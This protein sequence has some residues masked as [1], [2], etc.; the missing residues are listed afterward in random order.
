MICRV[1]FYRSTELV[2]FS[3]IVKNT[4]GMGHLLSL[5]CN[6]SRSSKVFTLSNADKVES[7]I[8]ESWWR[9]TR[10]H[11]CNVARRKLLSTATQSCFFS[12]GTPPGSKWR[13]FDGSS[14]PSKRSGKS[15]WIR[16]TKKPKNDRH[17]YKERSLCVVR[18]IFFHVAEYRKIWNNNLKIFTEN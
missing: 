1:K 14:K 7:F 6:W 5:R 4:A 15:R 18:R 2:Q 10:S 9:N 11:T 16:K 13:F 3:S 8:I 17:I 12:I